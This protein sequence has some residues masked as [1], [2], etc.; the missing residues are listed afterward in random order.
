MALVCGGSSASG[1]I[2]E[3]FGRHDIS[4]GTTCAFLDAPPAVSGFWVW[5]VWV[6]R[7]GGSD[8]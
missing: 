7:V 5:N 6:A 2:V 1:E 8:R 3:L 4:P